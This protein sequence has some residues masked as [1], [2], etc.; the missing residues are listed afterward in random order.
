MIRE[1]FHFQTVMFDEVLEIYIYTILI[2]KSIKCELHI[3]NET[4]VEF[5]TIN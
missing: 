4:A 2:M 5:E 3:N 1:V